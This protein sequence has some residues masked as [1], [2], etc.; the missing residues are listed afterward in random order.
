MNCN[1]QEK[2]I[3]VIFVA[4]AQPY[5]GSAIYDILGTLPE[6][7]V[8]QINLI[9]K[10]ISESY[11]TL[12]PTKKDFKG[13]VTDPDP[14]KHLQIKDLALIAASVTVG[15]GCFTPPKRAFNRKIKVNTLIFRLEIKKCV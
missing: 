7:M 10:Y 2:T 9:R 12:K 15:S 8:M 14:T 5:M 1:Q 3:Q 13:G 4:H 11:K 6:P